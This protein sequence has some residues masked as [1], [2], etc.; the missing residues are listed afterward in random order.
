MSSLKNKYLQQVYE[1][2]CKRD[3]DQ[4]EFHQAV[5]EVLQSFEPVIA[6]TPELFEGGLLERLVEPERGIQFRVAWVD[7][8][9]KTQ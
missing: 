8:N 3:P 5:F 1:Q 7:D 9:G 4:K 6:K 2:V